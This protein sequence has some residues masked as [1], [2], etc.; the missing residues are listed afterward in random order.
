MVACLN[1]GLLGTCTGEA[2]SG[3]AEGLMPSVQ[4]AFSMP[5]AKRRS[6]LLVSNVGSHQRPLNL[7]GGGTLCCGSKWKVF[8]LA[9]LVSFT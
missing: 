1:S 6:A 9:E 2:S 4:P 8:G 3:M 5:A 7:K